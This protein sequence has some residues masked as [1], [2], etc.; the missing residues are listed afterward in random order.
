MGLWFGI[1]GSLRITVDGRDVA[2]DSP[3]QRRLLAA[4]LVDAGSVVSAD[5]LAQVLWGDDPP[6]DP[7]GAVQTHVS[8]LRARLGEEGGAQ[9]RHVVVTRAP[10]YA[11]AVEPQQVDA[12]QFEQQ[13]EAARAAST[14]QA[15]AELLQQA[16]QLW[17]GRPL[18][19]FDIDRARV[20]AVRLDELWTAAVELQADAL[21]ALGRYAQAVGE[22]EAAVA[23]HPLR[24]HLRGQLMAALVGSGRRAE[25][26]ATYRDLRDVLVEELGWSRPRPC[27][28]S[29]GRSCSRRRT[30]RG[31][32]HHATSGTQGEPHRRASRIPCRRSCRIP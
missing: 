4:L 23:H 10:G 3:K 19:E 31:R 24:E 17:R 27:A 32:R 26:L 13:V 21:L 29:S 28:T 18:A 16:L 20:E 14:P 11:L 1:L 25:A 5:R 7:S 2:L 6:E 15:T 12:M 8:R 22:L 30:C 9:T